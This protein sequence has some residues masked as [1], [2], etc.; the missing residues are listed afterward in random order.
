MVWMYYREQSYTGDLFQLRQ[1]CVCWAITSERSNTKAISVL[2]DP[3]VFMPM[4][5]GISSFTSIC[6]L[7]IPFTCIFIHTL[8]YDTQQ[9][10]YTVVYETI[11]VWHITK[12]F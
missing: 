9:V 2:I 4:P 7:D 1:S 3:H 10:S 8:K 6:L 12:S 5:R 11:L